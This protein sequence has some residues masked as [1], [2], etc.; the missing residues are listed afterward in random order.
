MDKITTAREFT[1]PDKTREW[2]Q[3]AELPK[4]VSETILYRDEKTGTY[5][6]LLRY[7]PGYKG[8]DDPMCHDFEEV[9]YIAAGSAFNKRLGI[10]YE[11]G[12]VAVFPAGLKHGPLASPDGGLLV[13]FRYY[14]K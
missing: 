14:K 12:S 10:T 2:K 8:T 4:G 13:E 7:E 6:R 5:A 1:N 9:V 3:V 11:A